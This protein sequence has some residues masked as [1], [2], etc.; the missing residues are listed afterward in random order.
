MKKRILIVGSGLTGL[1]A[2]AAAVREDSNITVELFTRS[3]VIFKDALDVPCISLEI[4]DNFDHIIE[5]DDKEPKTICGIKFYGN[6][7]VTK[8]LVDQKQIL[9]KNLATGQEAQYPYD[10]LIL[11]TGIYTPVPDIEGNNLNNIYFHKT[12]DDELYIRG[13]IKDEVI[14]KAVVYGGGIEGLHMVQELWKQNV[15]ISWVED[16]DRILPEFD[17]EISE[18]VKRYIESKGIEVITGEEIRALIGNA[19]GDVVEV[20]TP[21]RILPTDLVLWAKGQRPATS[22][23]TDVGI[24]LG[25][26][27]A[28]AVNEFMETSVND[29]YC[30]GHCAEAFN[31][32]T[33]TP[34]WGFN[35]IN[36]CRMGIIA[37]I[38]AVREENKESYSGIIGTNLLRVF[39]TVIGK[40]GF[41]LKEAGELGFDTE[42][43][44]LPL[45]EQQGL[46]NTLS[47]NFIMLI[48]DK[49]SRRILGAQTIGCE[50]AE[51]SID[52]IATAI[53]MG[54]TVEDLINMDLSYPSMFK[55]TVYHPA[56]EAG[57][58]LKLKLDG[59]YESISSV[60]LSHPG[61]NSSVVLLDIRTTA[62][63]M[64]GTLPDSKNIPFDE[65]RA[66][67][68]ELNKEKVIILICKEQSLALKAYNMLRDAGYKKVFILEG[69]IRAYPYKLV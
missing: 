27:G 11:A 54:A 57:K 15:P 24:E 37:G 29:I 19:K 2:A 7:E 32:K 9:V 48:A 67:M 68:N 26:T 53:H 46:A 22:L 38:N 43:I 40:T 3:R 58:V 6:T 45:Q 21:E 65:L 64:L 59:M 10:K 42:Y 69:G 47:D 23:M 1:K 60:N 18:L 17:K 31:Y 63:V 61:D 30:A 66:R 41:T 33:K 62:E 44:L 36:A 34:Y 51:S 28:A 14:R 52:I 13:I 5:T 12:V 8:I 4:E 50:A 20:H 56:I 55:T 35:E 16:H 39:D 49:G 25:L